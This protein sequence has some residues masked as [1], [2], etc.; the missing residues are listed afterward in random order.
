[1]VPKAHGE[2]LAKHIPT[3]KLNF[4]PGHGHISLTTAYRPEI[5]KQ[6]MELL[7]A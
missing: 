3:A 1:M 2:W 5:I 6:A 4:V 7:K